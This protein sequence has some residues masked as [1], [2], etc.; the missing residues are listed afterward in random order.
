MRTDEEIRELQ[1]L[2]DGMI[3]AGMHPDVIKEKMA[4]NWGQRIK[5]VFQTSEI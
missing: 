3:E 4:K 5:C 2:H 1:Q